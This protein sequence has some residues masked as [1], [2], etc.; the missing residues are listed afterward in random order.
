MT[1]C[2]LASFLVRRDSTDCSTFSLQSLASASISKSESSKAAAAETV[3]VVDEDCWC[4]AGVGGGW[5]WWCWWL[6]LA[7]AAAVTSCDPAGLSTEERLKQR[8]NNY[9]GLL[10]TTI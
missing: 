7:D 10:C 6:P 1:S 5:W 9:R 2:L 8:I 4:E 3:A